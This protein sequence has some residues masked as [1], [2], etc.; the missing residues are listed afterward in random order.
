MRLSAYLCLQEKSSTSVTFLT[1][2]LSL[3]LSTTSEVLHFMPKE[4]RR[5]T[6]VSLLSA[7]VSS[8]FLS[9]LCFLSVTASHFSATENG[10][11]AFTLW[12][13]TWSNNAH[14]Q[15]LNIFESTEIRRATLAS[16]ASIDFWLLISQDV[17]VKRPI[18]TIYS[19]RILLF[20]N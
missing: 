8:F 6:L 13:F 2:S 12:L 14:S 1:L 10:A 20:F 15:F 19:K 4:H 11:T 16:S 17:V 18:I 9:P 5:P 7:S 3:L